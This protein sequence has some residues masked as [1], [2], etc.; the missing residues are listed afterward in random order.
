MNYPL[1]H[2]QDCWRNLRELLGRHR[3]VIC[4]RCGAVIDSQTGEIVNHSVPSAVAYIV[5]LVAA[6]AAIVLLVWAS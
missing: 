3:L 5:L 1:G 4:Q 6:I 2:L